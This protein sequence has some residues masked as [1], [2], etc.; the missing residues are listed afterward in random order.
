MDLHQKCLKMSHATSFDD[1]LCLKI[2]VPWHGEQFEVE[3]FGHTKKVIPFIGIKGVDFSQLP[4]FGYGVYVSN[5]QET[6]INLGMQCINSR[7]YFYGLE[8]PNCLLQLYT[9]AIIL[10]YAFRIDLQTLSN[11]HRFVHQ[12]LASTILRPDFP[13]EVLVHLEQVRC[14]ENGMQILIG[15]KMILP[16]KTS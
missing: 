12:K 16:S 2:F 8:K 3:F 14:E 1:D 13:Q 4:A 9:C 6:K 10:S 7:F 11:V 15:P 5:D